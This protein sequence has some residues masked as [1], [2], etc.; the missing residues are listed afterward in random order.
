MV[1]IFTEN[2]ERITFLYSRIDNDSS[3]EFCNWKSNRLRVGIVENPKQTP[4]ILY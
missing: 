1:Q 4:A 2:L 3:N